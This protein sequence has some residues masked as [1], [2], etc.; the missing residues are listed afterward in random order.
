MGS[1]NKKFFESHERGFHTPIVPL[2]RVFP[3]FYICGKE[4]PY[5]NIPMVGRFVIKQIFSALPHISFVVCQ[6]NAIKIPILYYK[7]STFSI[8]SNKNI[9]YAFK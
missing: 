6:L 1:L 2:K 4:L 3:S 5:Y 7:N 8:G 9:A